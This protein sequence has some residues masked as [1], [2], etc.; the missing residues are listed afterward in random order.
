M[1]NVFERSLIKTGD[2]GLTIIIPKSWAS[3]YQLEPG[4]V[5][6]VKT[7]GK[8]VVEPIVLGKWKRKRKK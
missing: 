1:P 7:N 6:R 5:V 3:F 8:L 4:D 2:G